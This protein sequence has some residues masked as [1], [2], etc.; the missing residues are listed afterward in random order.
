MPRQKQILGRWGEKAAEQFLTEKGYV[1]LD[2]NARTKYGEIDLVVRKNE[3]IVFVEV[4]SRSSTD[5][6]FPEEAVTSLKQQH[7]RDAA[8]IYMQAHPELNGDWRIDVISVRRVHGEALE[9]VHLENA[10]EG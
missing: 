2:R 7:L 4:K 5:F 8:E 10:V 3:E 6:G 1:I 9:I